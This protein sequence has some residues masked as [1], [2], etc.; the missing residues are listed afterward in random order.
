MP[1]ATICQKP[2][3]LRISSLNPHKPVIAWEGISMMHVLKTKA[4][5]WRRLVFVSPSVVELA[6]DTVDA[7]SKVGSKAHTLSPWLRL[8][9]PHF[10]NGKE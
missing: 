9:A 4:L 10:K 7:Q 3:S 6:R 5:Q 2:F 1:P 8:I